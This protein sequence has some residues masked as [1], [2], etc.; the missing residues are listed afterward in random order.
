MALIDCDPNCLPTYDELKRARYE[1]LPDGSYA[2]QIFP[3]QKEFVN[4]HPF[5]LHLYEIDQ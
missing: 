4:F 1:F 2:A 3:S 5:T